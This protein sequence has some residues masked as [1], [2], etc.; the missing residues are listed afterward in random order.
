VMSDEAM[1]EEARARARVRLRDSGLL[2]DPAIDPD[3][4]VDTD[5]RGGEATAAA[6]A[7]FRV[8]A[9]ARL[10][11][12]VR[13]WSGDRA[14][15][16]HLAAEGDHG[17]ALTRLDHVR[18]GE[19]GEMRVDRHGGGVEITVFEVQKLIPGV[20]R[21]VPPAL[22]EME[23]PKGSRAAPPHGVAVPWPD[24]L[25]AIE[26]HAEPGPTATATASA[27]AAGRGGHAPAQAW[28]RR[29]SLAAADVLRAEMGWGELPPVLAD[30]GAGITGVLE[31]TAT[32]AATGAPAVRIWHGTWLS[33]RG[34]LVAVRVEA[35]QGPDDAVAGP[36]DELPVLLRFLD[37]DGEGMRADISWS[38]VA[39]MGAAGLDDIEVTS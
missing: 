17:V 38:L 20:W 26:A 34:R 37:T 1:S 23:R 10:R 32:V 22:R 6:K 27:A 15:F 30:L 21:V 2:A 11:V 39:A 13:A 18:H 25:A 16:C 4:A 3:P 35:G 14:V 19:S 7:L 31:V 24:G 5:T 33:A 36:D 9:T 28:E 8:L 12:D 29:I